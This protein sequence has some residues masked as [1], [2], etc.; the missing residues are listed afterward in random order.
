VN[1]STALAAVIVD[2]LVRNGVRE[3]VLAPGSRN[4]PLAFAL[5]AAD[6]AGRVRLH[7]R[8]DERSAGFLAVGL[9]KASGTPV[10]VACTSGTAAANLHPA[11]IEAHHSGTPLI[12]L[13]ADRPP[14]LRGVGANQTIDQ[15]KLYGGAVSMF[16][17]MGV[18]STPGEAP[19]WRSVVCR[20][21]ATRGVAHL[22]IAFREPLV[23]DGGEAPAGRADG[24]P[25]TR[26]RSAVAQPEPLT[27]PAR[28]LVVAGDGASP[29]D[30]GGL[31]L[32]AEP[33]SGHWSSALTHGALLLG[34]DSFVDRQVPDHVVV[35]GRPTLGRALGRLLKRRVP[36]TVIDDRPQWTDPQHVAG[37]VL[38]VVS[39][40]EVE[41]D[42][43][44]TGGWR[45]ADRLACGAVATALSDAWPSGLRLARDL[46][47]PL[48][49]GA[50]L[51]LGSSAPVRDMD[52]VGPRRADLRI[53]ANRGAAGIDG[54]VSTAIGVALSSRGPT[55]AYMGD[56]TFLHDNSGLILGPDE[57]SPDLT[58]VVAN[59]DGGG[60]FSLLEQGGPEHAG[61]FE[62]V[63][64]T[65]HGVQLGALCAAT[66]TAYS[67]IARA[68][69]LADAL[70]PSAGLRVI[71]VRTDRGVD[72]K[73]HAAMRDAV[74]ASIA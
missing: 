9:A 46:V 15:I 64:G 2:E 3:A 33:T 39:H 58:I 26:V 72:R 60:I 70:Q 13:T 11:V 57:P 62:R 29:I 27:V 4:A 10:A 25:W 65:P 19:Y 7:V 28:T 50:T 6:A 21:V 69:E 23:P 47:P 43:D 16:H 31:P 12:V 41:D 34:A 71:E 74:A 38:R 35:L 53:L 30:V 20:A 42:T 54:T 52:L 51:F 14:D 49:S 37:E 40:L 55:Y 67:R 24:G 17:E 5:H 68:E 1:P 44:W 66:G 73:V 18:P 59:N 63:F 36:V 8:I 45:E 56:L 22:N 48:P 32:I 61:A